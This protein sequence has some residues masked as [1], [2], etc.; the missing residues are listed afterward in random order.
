MCY[1]CCEVGILHVAYGYHL[2]V[3]KY[4]CLVPSKQIVLK[5]HADMKLGKDSDKDPSA[6]L[7]EAH[8]DDWIILVKWSIGNY[9]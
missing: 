6:D 9:S 8:V 5:L 1:P 4:L 3:S 2:G 7:D